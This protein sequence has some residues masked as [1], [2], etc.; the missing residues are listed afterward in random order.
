MPSC[1]ECKGYG[2][3]KRT[4]ICQHCKGKKC[5]LCENVNMQWEECGKC[6]EKF[7]PAYKNKYTSKK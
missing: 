5:F 7:R 2:L 4:F 3:V 1:S 6:N